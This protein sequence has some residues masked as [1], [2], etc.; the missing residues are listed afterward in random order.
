LPIA[1][2]NEA[3]EA[4]KGD[5]ALSERVEQVF[6]VLNELGLHARP[7]TRIVRTAST[8]KCDVELERDGQKANAKSV[9]G[10]LLLGCHK[11]AKVTV[12]ATGPDALAAVTA[13]GELFASR[14]GET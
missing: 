1:T 11:G 4:T 14:F 7:L 3:L 6:E 9:M 8:H 5:D 12:R 13:I 2:S 10:M